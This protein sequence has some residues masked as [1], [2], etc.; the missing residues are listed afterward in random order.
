MSRTLVATLKL[1]TDTTA[2]VSGPLSAATANGPYYATPSWDQKLPGSTRFVVLSDWNNEA[3]LDRETG[4]VW[5]KAPLRPFPGTP[6]LP[7]DSGLRDWDSALDRCTTMAVGGRMGWRLP[8][9]HELQSLIDPS[10]ITSPGPGLPAGHPFFGVQEGY[11]W[12]ATTF[13]DPDEVFIMHGRTGHVGRTLNIAEHYV[14][15]VR[16][17]SGA[18]RY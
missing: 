1:V 8:S 15:C 12:S 3:V 11:Y 16:G 2:F 9:I 10:M 6:T 18:D 13:R 4:L 17:G 14:W 5:E 7:P